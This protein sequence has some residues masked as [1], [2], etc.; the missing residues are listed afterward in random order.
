HPS[1]PGPVVFAH[2]SPVW[3][4]V[5]GRP[6]RRPASARWL[7]DWLDRF[8]ALLDEHGR[9]AGDDQRADLATVVDQARSWYRAIAGDPVC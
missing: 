2:T 1:V 9:F 3:V 6:V 5:G 8:E 7:L 4:E